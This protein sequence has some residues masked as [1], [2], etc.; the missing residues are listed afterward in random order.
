VA[1]NQHD[2]KESSD[3]VEES[4]HR[5]FQLESAH[6]GPEEALER[7]RHRR[8]RFVA[9]VFRVR[10]DGQG[11]RDDVRRL[12]DDGSGDKPVRSRER[13]DVDESRDVVKKSLHVVS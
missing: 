10:A 12:L 6:S 2:V 9:H 13:D 11:R 5:R 7:L 3:D 1:K 4:S 8:R